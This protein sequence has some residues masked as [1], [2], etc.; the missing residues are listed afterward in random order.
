MSNRVAIKWLGLLQKSVSDRHLQRAIIKA[1]ECLKTRGTHNKIPLIYRSVLT[2]L[3]LVASW[4]GEVSDSS[5][6][7]FCLSKI[8]SKSNN[9]MF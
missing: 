1:Y 9:I 2:G 8:R 4:F 7:D 5:R 6:Y 3:T